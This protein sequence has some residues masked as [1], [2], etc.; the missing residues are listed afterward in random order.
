MLDPE[1]INYAHLLFPIRD[2]TA[3][4]SRCTPSLFIATTASGN[5]LLIRINKHVGS[6][7][8]YVIISRRFFP[9]G[10][11]KET[12]NIITDF[13]RFRRSTGR[14]NVNGNLLIIFGTNE[15]P[16]QLPRRFSSRIYIFIRIGRKAKT[17]RLEAIIFQRFRSTFY[18]LEGGKLRL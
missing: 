17:R 6:A 14:Y 10:K 5:K 9:R 16:P 2:T 15:R 8:L 7:T 3:A 1:A 4:Y 13:H 11:K 12:V 18:D